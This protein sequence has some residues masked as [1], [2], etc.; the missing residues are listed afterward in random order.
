[1]PALVRW[2]GKVKPGSRSEAPIITPDFYPTILEAAGV[3]TSPRQIDGV[4]LVPLL[5]GADNPKRPALYWHYP[6]CD[7]EPYSVVRKG[8]MK[9][10]EFLADG[11]R[12]LYNLRDDPEE[13]TNLADRLPSKT[14]SLCRALAV[15]HNSLAQTVF[16]N[17]SEEC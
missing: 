3:K 17:L 6:H 9:L 1:V 8:D 2:P 10:I 4:S 11:R 5:R 14:S 13:R 7:A 15:T 12:E 16:A